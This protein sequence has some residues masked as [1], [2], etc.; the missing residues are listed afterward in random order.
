MRANS[1]V[2]RIKLNDPKGRY[3]RVMDPAGTNQSLAF[4]VDPD[5]PTIHA[6]TGYPMCI[7][8]I[9]PALGVDKLC[10]VWNRPLSTGN[11][12]SSP[13]AAAPNSIVPLPPRGQPLTK[14]VMDDF[15]EPPNVPG[16]SPVA[17]VQDIPA[18]GLVRSVQA[19]VNFAGTAPQTIQ[20]GGGLNATDLASGVNDPVNNNLYMAG[21]VQHPCDPSQQAPFMVGDMVVYAGTLSDDGT[22]QSPRPF[23]SAWMVQAMVGIFTKPCKYVDGTTGALLTVTDPVTGLP[24]PGTR[25]GTPAVVDPNNTA[26]NLGS[27]ISYQYQD[28][29]L[30]GMEGISA[31]GILVEGQDRMRLRGFSTD[32]T[33]DVDIY[34]Y[35]NHPGDGSDITLRGLARVVPERIPFSR[36]E[37]FIQ[38]DTCLRLRN[39][40]LQVNGKPGGVAPPP[41]DLAAL[42]PIADNHQGID[43]G[44]PRHF[45]SI[46]TGA[47][48]QRSARRR[49]LRTAGGFV[50]RN[51]PLPGAS[52]LPLNGLTLP[53][54]DPTGK[55]IDGTGPGAF[56]VN[57][58]PIA[59]QPT[60]ANGLLAGQY[61]QPIGEY[62]TV[63]TIAFG[64]APRPNNFEC[65]DFLVYG[66]NVTTLFF[67]GTLPP[68]TPWPGGL[69]GP[70]NPGAPVCAPQLPPGAVPAG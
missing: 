35:V 28:D 43:F 40:C 33:R 18:C 67:S 10:P 9:D 65:S 41:G 42:P 16:A 31:D 39:I 23:I 38:R 70:S 21:A 69:T 50:L 26:C 30:V 52:P 32:P 5:N 8:R 29:A 17:G 60:Y 2:T 47:P 20:L 53:A 15:N 37:L 24:V 4:A 61:W 56:D 25:A 14:F 54:A 55:C 11:S 66:Q 59:C 45:Y 6:M 13:V 48:A 57:G 64:D 46:I 12:V 1:N 49:A 62:I 19:G 44:A 36:W 7:P 58:L 27:I 68:L 22:A 34:A 3:G 63:E 51:K